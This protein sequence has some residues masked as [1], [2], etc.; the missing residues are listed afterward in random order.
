MASTSF[1]YGLSVMVQVFPPLV[2]LRTVA[3]W[4]QLWPLPKI[5][6]RT[7]LRDFIHVKLK[8]LIQLIMGYCFVNQIYSYNF[9]F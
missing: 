5:I 9:K 1:L 7:P 2:A 3:P 8:L 6:G 4:G